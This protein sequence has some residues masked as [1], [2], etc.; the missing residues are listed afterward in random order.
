MSTHCYGIIHPHINKIPVSFNILIK[1]FQIEFRHIDLHFLSISN[2]YINQ[3]VPNR[4]SI[5]NKYPLKLLRAIAKVELNF[6][7]L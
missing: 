6:D 4:I 7:E 3:I 2:I 1:L 5:F